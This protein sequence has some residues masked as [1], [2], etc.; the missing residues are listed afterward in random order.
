M[1]F[2]LPYLISRWK[3]TQE[4]LTSRILNYVGLSEILP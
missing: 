1:T 2:D 4:N 3:Q